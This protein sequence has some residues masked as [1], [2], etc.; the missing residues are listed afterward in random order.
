MEIEI[1]KGDILKEKVE[2]IVNPANVTGYMGYGV[3][4]AIVKAGG[5]EIEKEALA[6]APILLGEPIVTKAGKLPF[7]AIVHSATI[8]DSRDKIEKGI[9]GKA[10]LNALFVADELGY[11]S[12]AIPGIGTGV[13]GVSEE[14]S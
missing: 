12:V 1:K 4:K 6:K 10:V 11:T 14:V 13:G 3:A 8:D 5:E 9:V 7:K 2:V